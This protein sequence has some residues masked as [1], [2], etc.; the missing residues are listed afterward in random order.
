[1]SVED[2]QRSRGVHQHIWSA[3]VDPNILASQRRLKPHH[4]VRAERALGVPCAR[5]AFVGATE[6]SL[7][8]DCS[9]S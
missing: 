6:L 5:C 7:Q 3:G 8:V 2:V 9:M 4:L 1:M